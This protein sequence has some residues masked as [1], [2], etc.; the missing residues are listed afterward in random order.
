MIDPS[1]FS[2]KPKL[3]TTMATVTILL[4]VMLH[5]INIWVDT[6]L[7][8]AQSNIIYETFAMIVHITLELLGIVLVIGWM[9]EK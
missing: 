1:G 9:D 7:G 4:G 6:A 2:M 3:P 8:I 5:D